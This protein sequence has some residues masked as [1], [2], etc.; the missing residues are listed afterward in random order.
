MPMAGQAKPF[1]F[2]ELRLLVLKL[3]IVKLEDLI[4]IEANDVIVMRIRRH[5]VNH[6]VFGVQYGLCQNARI[7]KHFEVSI[8]R[9]SSDLRIFD[10]HSLDD[11]LSA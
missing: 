4:A 2:A 7:A 9:R 5:F 8:N 10:P 1:G 6:V 11:L 3:R